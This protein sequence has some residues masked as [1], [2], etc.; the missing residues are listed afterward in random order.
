[1]AAKTK[2]DTADKK[3]KAEK[4]PPHPL[5]SFFSYERSLTPTSGYFFGVNAAGEEIP[6]RVEEETLTGSMS[7]YSNGLTNEFASL[8]ETEDKKKDPGQANVKRTDTA[9]VPAGCDRLRV[10]FSVTVHAKSLTAQSSSDAVFRAKVDDFAKTFAELGGYRDLAARYLWTIASGR[11]LWRNTASLED[12]IAVVKVG[13]AS[14]KFDCHAID[15]ENFPGI[16]GLKEMDGQDVSALID[17]IADALSVKSRRVT[18]LWVEVTGKLPEGHDIYP[19]QDFVEKETRK[20]SKEKARTLASEWVVR[21]GVKCRQAIF[22]P[23]KIGNALRTIDEWHGVDGIGPIAVEPFG[24]VKHMQAALRLPKGRTGMS[25]YEMLRDNETILADMKANGISDR[26]RFL[27][28]CLVRGGVY[29][30]PGAEKEK[31]KTEEAA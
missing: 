4:K 15:E 26:A 5:P 7:A 30:G 25:L 3:P 16:D 22:H 12:P 18:R 11:V 21:D 8:P 20:D 6:V 27:A 31:P 1:M 10:R 13:D 28:A 23:Q 17:V 9:R 24:F 2:T 29:S 19:S 14:F